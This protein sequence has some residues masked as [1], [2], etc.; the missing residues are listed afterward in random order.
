[1]KR[2][3][4]LIALMAVVLSTPAAAQNA[5]TIVGPEARAPDR[6]A[7]VQLGLDLT[8]AQRRRIFEHI[9]HSGVVAPEGFQVQVGTAVP[10]HIELR[11]LPTELVHDVP[12]LG[13]YRYAKV[14]LKVLLVDEDRRLVEIIEN[15]LL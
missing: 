4:T 12:A 3:L 7:G 13:E 9:D 14:D 15:P 5:P 10:Q 1:M 6:P 8:Y 11:P 2:N